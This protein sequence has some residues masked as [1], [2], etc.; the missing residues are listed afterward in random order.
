MAVL[1]SDHYGRRP[2]ILLSVAGLFIFLVLMASVTSYPSLAGVMTFAMCGFMASFS[3]ALGP[4][5]WVG[6]LDR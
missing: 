3:L 4:L 6:K 2:L 5:T 1:Y